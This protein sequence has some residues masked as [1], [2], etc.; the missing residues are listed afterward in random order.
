M[1]W[2][3]AP[4]W[5]VAPIAL[6]WLLLI[7]LRLMAT[8]AGW[9]ETRAGATSPPHMLSCASCRN[10]DPRATAKRFITI[11]TKL[12]WLL[13]VVTYAAWAFSCDATALRIYVAMLRV[14]WSLLRI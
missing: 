4:A 2:Q 3:G 1:R 14:T 9:R 5:A 10:L 8:G 12:T 11:T 13:A 6:Q 7:G